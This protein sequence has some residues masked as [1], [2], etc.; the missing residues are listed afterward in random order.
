MRSS[1]GRRGSSSWPCS[2][3]FTCWIYLI[4][5]WGQVVQTPTGPQQTPDFSVSAANGFLPGLLLSLGGFGLQLAFFA[6]VLI[7]QF[8]ALFWFL[9]RGRTYVI[10]PGEYDELQ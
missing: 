4:F 6:L 1:A 7:I 8:V 3:G 2:T 5:P 9:S 10:Y